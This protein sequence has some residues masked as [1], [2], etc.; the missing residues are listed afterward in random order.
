M[1]KLL[2]KRL[3][4]GVLTALIVVYVIYLFVSAN[5]NVIQT[6][7]AIEMTVTDKVYSSGFIIRSEDYINNS[8]GGCLSYEL[9]DGDEVEANGV[10]ANIYS[11]ESDAIARQQ[12]EAIDS[13]I[14]E[15]KALSD[16]YY[17]D[18]VNLDVVDNELDNGILTYLTSLNEG[19]YSQANESLHNVL[20]SINK[21][22]LITGQVEDFSQ[23]IA[24]LEAEKQQYESSSN[25]SIGQITSQKAGYFISYTDGYEKALDYAKIKDLTVEQFDNI[26]QATVPQNAIGKVVDNLNWYVVCKVSSDDALSLSFFENE[27]VTLEMPFASTEVIPAQLIRVNQE[28][29]NSNA[30]V[31]LKCNYMNDEL[32]SIR[33]ESIEIGTEKFKGLRVSKNALHDD[34]VT[35]YSEDANGNEIKEKKKVQGV[36][37]VH[38]NEL[39]FKEVSIIYS[40]SDYVICDPE[41]D[42]GELYSD[43]TI[44]L[45]D[46]VVVEGDNLHDGKIVS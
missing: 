34:Y 35:K 27:D 5:F 23:R 13:Q 33:N 3:L 32:A 36:Y 45:Y 39:Q 8:S 10:V 24:Q 1:D 38:G 26:K 25:K 28:D 20:N 42:D 18:N 22:Q 43:E 37:I 2:F 12:I 4:L 31:V 14:K 15:L 17:S 6:E 21:R 40:G 16:V 11:S 41:P 7:N 19:K 9:D 44:Q 29:Q 46:K 30:V